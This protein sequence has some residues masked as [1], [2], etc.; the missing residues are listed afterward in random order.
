MIDCKNAYDDLQDAGVEVVPTH[1]QSRRALLSPQGVLALDYS[2]ID[3]QDEEL[4]LLLEEIG[5]FATFAFYPENAPHEVWEKQEARAARYVF[6]KYFP[7]SLLASYMQQGHATPWQLAEHLNLPEDF[8]RK[9]LTF[10]QDV[11]GIDFNQL[12]QRQPV[13]PSTPGPAASAPATAPTQ[14]TAPHSITL[15]DIRAIGDLIAA[16]AEHQDTTQLRRQQNEDYA[17]R[18]ADHLDYSG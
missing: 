16:M 13:A 17:E 4:A 18:Y 7:P 12:V 11:H 9:M 3:S 1:F 6:E 5:H 15:E 10:Y 8:I 14:A 2:K